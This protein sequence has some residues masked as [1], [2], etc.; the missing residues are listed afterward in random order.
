MMKLSS[1]MKNLLND[2]D[3][4]AETYLLRTLR[5]SRPMKITRMIGSMNGTR[6]YHG[7]MRSHGL[8]LEFG[9]NPHHLNILASLS[10]IKP[11]IRNGQHVVGW[12]LDT[13]MEETYPELTLLESNSIIR[14]TSGTRLWKIVNLKYSLNND[15][16]YV[17]VKEDEYDDPT[18]TRE[19]ACRAYQEIFRKMDEG[20]MVT[21]AE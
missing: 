16:E 21:R 11:D 2:K 1:Q 14:N 15:E 13:V 4:V 6:T 8:T 12:M 20:W 9:P 18:I 10:T 17:A 7:S 19:K 5:N 3:E